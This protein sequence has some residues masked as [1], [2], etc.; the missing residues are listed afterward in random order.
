MNSRAVT[1]TEPIL[2]LAFNR[3]DYLAGLIERLREVQPTRIFIAIDGP[4]EDRPEEASKVQ[5]CRD[6][7]GTIDWPCEITTLFQESNLGCGL[8]V[9]TAITWFFDNVERGIILEDDLEPD[10]SFFGYCSE[11]LDRYE[12]DPRVFAI[13]GCNYVPSAD[14]G[15]PDQSYRFSQV[16]HI[17]GWAQSIGPR[18]F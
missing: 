8:G 13:S 6:L 1:I 11:L 12:Q 10:P 5:A 7:V 4:R 2:L 14:Q 16:A 3:P 17:W 15:F 9:S 18:H